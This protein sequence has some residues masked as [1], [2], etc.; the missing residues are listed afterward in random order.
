MTNIIINL[1][2]E[3]T[4]YLLKDLT[5]HTIKKELFWV[6]IIFNTDIWSFSKASQTDKPVMKTYFK[7]KSNPIQSTKTPDARN[8]KNKTI[9]KGSLTTPQNRQENYH[10]T[11]YRKRN[12][13][14]RARSRKMKR[15]AAICFLLGG[16]ERT[17]DAPE[18]GWALGCG[19][20][21][22]MVGQLEGLRNSGGWS[23]LVL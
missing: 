5:V 20:E 23:F 13:R 19:T 9:Q 17:G 10:C 18:F 11:R 6:S 21:A 15:K 22:P 8:S 3:C 4:V 1:V 14:P 2:A 12:R 7:L 16:W